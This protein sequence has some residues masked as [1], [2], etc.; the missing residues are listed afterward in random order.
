MSISGRVLFRRKKLQLCIYSIVNLV[1]PYFLPCVG[2]Y[3]NQLASELHRDLSYGK[4]SPVPLKDSKIATIEKTE[5]WDGKDGEV[6]VETVMTTIALKIVFS[7][8]KVF[9]VVIK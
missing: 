8:L 5:P 1:I 9:K 2:C 6:N 7:N 3:T 4:G